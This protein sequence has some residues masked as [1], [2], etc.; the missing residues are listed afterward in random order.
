MPLVTIVTIGQKNQLVGKRWVGHSL[1]NPILDADTE[2]VISAEERETADP[3]FAWIRT[4]PT[5]EHNP[6]P[7]PEL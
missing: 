4:R 6:V 7:P 2:L 1:W 5:K 3:E